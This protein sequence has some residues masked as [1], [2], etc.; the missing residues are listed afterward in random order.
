MAMHQFTI[1]RDTLARTGFFTAQKDVRYYLEGVCIEYTEHTALAMA[2][3]GHF[4]GISKYT[5]EKGAQGNIG[6]GVIIIPNVV[7]KE[8]QKMKFN[9]DIAFQQ[10]EDGKWKVV[11]LYGMQY[12]FTPIDGKFPDIRRVINFALNPENKEEANCLDPQYTSLV[13]KAA[14]YGKRK[15]RVPMRLVSWTHKGTN[16][17]IFCT[18]DNSLFGMIMSLQGMEQIIVPEWIKDFCGLPAPIIEPILEEETA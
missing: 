4:A 11:M 16:G 18:Q 13:Y 1:D 17:S 15:E 3:N 6:E 8:V 10:R 12:T 2:T 9:I 7:I 5:L 14:C